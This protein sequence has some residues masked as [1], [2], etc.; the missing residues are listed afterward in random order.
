MT[1]LQE[2]CHGHHDELSTALEIGFVGYFCPLGSTYH[3]EIPKQGHPL[4]HD[5]ERH[6]GLSSDVFS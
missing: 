4:G 1:R 2:P 6:Q 3:F 5:I